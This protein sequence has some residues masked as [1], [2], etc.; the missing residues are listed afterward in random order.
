MYKEGRKVYIFQFCI[1]G[2]II[3]ERG[4][5]EKGHSVVFSSFLSPGL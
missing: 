3:L 2:S 4:P 1:V 5:E